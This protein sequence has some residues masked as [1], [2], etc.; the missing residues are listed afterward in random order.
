[1]ST[2]TTITRPPGALAPRFAFDAKWL[3]I[4]ACVLVTVYLG[5]VPLAT[6]LVNWC[7]IYRIL[8]IDTRRR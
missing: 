7:P 1:M 4:G 8:G 2:T 6:G 5:I 3:I